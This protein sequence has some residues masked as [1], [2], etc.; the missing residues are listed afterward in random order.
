MSSNKIFKNAADNLSNPRTNT[1]EG[2]SSLTYP[3]LD[4]DDCILNNTEY[5]N[6]HSFIIF[7]DVNS[8]ISNNFIDKIRD[9]LQL[10]P[11]SNGYRYKGN[12]LMVIIA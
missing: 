4:S 1:Y 5:Y 8:P 9:S 12:Y 3:V 7:E 10:T 2:I 11:L 6:G